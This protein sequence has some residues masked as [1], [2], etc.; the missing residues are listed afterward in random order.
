MF[1]NPVT[2]S[3]CSRDFS[4]LLATVP[5]DSW[6]G[7]D[8]RPEERGRISGGDDVCCVTNGQRSG[9]ED[10]NCGGY[11]FGITRLLFPMTS[12]RSQF[13]I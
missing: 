8:I 12:R 4:G 13:R 5:D 10:R 1:F 6:K 7:W 3:E 2:K 11:E 9:L